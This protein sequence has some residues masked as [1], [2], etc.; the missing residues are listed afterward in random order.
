MPK[1]ALKGDFQPIPKIEINM[2]LTKDQT[3]DLLSILKTRF[4]NNMSRHVGLEWSTI[5]EKLELHPEKISCLYAMEDSGGEP[6]VVGFDEKTGEYIFVDCSAQSPTG[7]R[8]ICY[9]A[10]GQREREKK[11]VYPAGNALEI[12]AAMG[13]AI[14]NEDQYRE[15]QT[16]GEFDT[17][18]SSWIETPITIRELGGAIFADRR[19]DHVFVYHNGAHTFYGSRGFR[20][21]LRI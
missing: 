18:T 11:G 8:S 6:D 5:L 16:L 17:T 12:A 14:L 1:N 10:E 13:V 7:R 20:G 9:D 19:Y 3:N 4:E 21:L 15:L 2:E